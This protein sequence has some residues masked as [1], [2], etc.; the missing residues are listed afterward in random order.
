MKKPM[1]KTTKK[2]IAKRIKNTIMHRIFLFMTVVFLLAFMH[3]SFIVCNAQ[4]QQEEQMTPENIKSEYATTTYGILDGL[5]SIEIN[6]IVQTPDGY[7]WV[8][9]YA[10]LYRFDGT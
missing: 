6:A 1:K 9:S 7:I 8:G 5:S 2:A 3:G 4:E 10:G